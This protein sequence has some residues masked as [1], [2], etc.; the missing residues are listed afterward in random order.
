MRARVPAAEAVLT[1]AMIDPVGIASVYHHA[2][3]H[4][5]AI[6]RLAGTPMSPFVE[7]YAAEGSA[8]AN[9]R[10]TGATIR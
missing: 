2:S 7:K 6:S 3:T 10:L 9:G 8:S 4:T 1:S 5:D